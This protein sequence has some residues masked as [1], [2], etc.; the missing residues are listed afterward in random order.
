MRYATVNEVTGKVINVDQVGS[1]SQLDDP[2]V[3]S[4]HIVETDWV[5]GQD[6]AIGDEWDGRIPT[7]FTRPAN[8]LVDLTAQELLDR[9]AAQRAEAQ[10]TE[11]ALR[12][13]LS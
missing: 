13:L 3:N 7:T 8:E 2:P 10:A 6:P 5:A 4:R 12:A 9:L 11:D 1:S